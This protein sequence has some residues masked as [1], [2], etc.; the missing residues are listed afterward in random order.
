VIRADDGLN[1]P[2][3]MEAYNADNG[4]NWWVQAHAGSVVALMGVVGGYVILRNYELVS[5]TSGR[6]SATATPL[7]ANSVMRALWGFG[8]WPKM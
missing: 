3:M 1:K 5:K 8:K 6:L 2:R 7:F 4:G